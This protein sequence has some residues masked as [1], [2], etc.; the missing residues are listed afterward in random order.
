MSP[1]RA[2]KPK[3]TGR[4]VVCRNVTLTLSNVIEYSGLCVVVSCVR[5][6]AAEHGSWGAV[7][8]QYPV[9]TGD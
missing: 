5:A 1:R 6:E 7:A 3:R 8:R 2:S 4:L 9:K